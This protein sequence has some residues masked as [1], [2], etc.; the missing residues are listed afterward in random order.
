MLCWFRIEFVNFVLLESISRTGSRQQRPV[1]DLAGLFW[2]HY[3]FDITHE[4]CVLMLPE[5]KTKQK[6]GWVAL[7][8]SVNLGVKLLIYLH[9]LHPVCPKVNDWQDVKIQLPTNPLITTNESKIL[10]WK[11]HQK[12]I[13][14]FK[15]RFWSLLPVG[16]RWAFLD[17]HVLRRQVPLR[18][19]KMDTLWTRWSNTFSCGSSRVLRQEY[20]AGSKDNWMQKF[21]E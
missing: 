15:F 5:N 2:T 10:N 6:R 16:E 4:M 11:Q 17:W 3:L 8:P 14:D 9:T 7:G 12:Q 18:R 21:R 19:M 20:C 1:S 13:L